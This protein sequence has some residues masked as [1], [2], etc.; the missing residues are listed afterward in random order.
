MTAAHAPGDCDVTVT[1]GPASSTLTAAYRY[2]GVDA[3]PGIGWCDVQWPLATTARVNTDSEL[4]FGRVWKAGVTAPAGAP[5]GI[6]GQLG[7]GPPGSDPRSTVGWRWLAASWNPSC[8]GC[9]ENDEFMRQFNLPQTGAWSYVY[10]FSDDGGF[11]FVFCDFDPGAP[12]FGTAE[13][14]SLTVTP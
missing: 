6:T 8:S 1:K 14:G 2:T 10:R 4:V 12:P 7:H 9:G 13:M 11:T 3:S 5:A